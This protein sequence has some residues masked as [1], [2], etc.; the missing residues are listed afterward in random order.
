MTLLAASRN[1][2]QAMLVFA[3]VVSVAFAFLT[4]RGLS[5][6]ARYVLWAFLAFLLV[7]IGL[8]WV[9]YPFSR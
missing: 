4:K 9:M 3:F 2:F 8:G 1:H 5:E 6:R 7:A